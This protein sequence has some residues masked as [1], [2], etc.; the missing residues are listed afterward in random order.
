MYRR[1]IRA[2]FTDLCYEGL[3]GEWRPVGSV[4]FGNASVIEFNSETG[5]FE[6]LLY[7]PE[8][9]SD[10]KEQLEAKLG[11]PDENYSG[12]NLR[13]SLWGRIRIHQTKVLPRKW[14]LPCPRY[15]C[16]THLG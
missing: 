12:Q 13:R 7:V 1:C 2:K 4:L 3:K 9:V 14:H 10:T 11:N 8:D 15:Y 16:E 6:N 5:S